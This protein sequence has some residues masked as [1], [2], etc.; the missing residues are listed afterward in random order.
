MG[1]IRKSEGYRQLATFQ[2]ST[3]IYDVTV[4]FCERFLDSRSRPIDQ[5]VQAARNAVSPWYC[6]R[7]KPEKMPVTNFGDAPPIPNARA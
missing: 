4:W 5:M 2:T 7:Q 1:K 6:A 3:I